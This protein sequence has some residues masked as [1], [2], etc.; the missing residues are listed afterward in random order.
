MEETPTDFGK[1]Y[2]F[3]MGRSRSQLSFFGDP[4]G[5]HERYP[6]RFKLSENGMPVKST[7]NDGNFLRNGPDFNCLGLLK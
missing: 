4:R 5:V 7:K 6:G 3:R 1:K 2:G